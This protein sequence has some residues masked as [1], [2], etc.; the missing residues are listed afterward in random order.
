MSKNKNEESIKL[1]SLGSDMS[2]GDEDAYDPHLHREREAP[3]TNVETLIHI[4][5]GSLGTGILAMPEAFLNAGMINGTIFTIIIGAVATYGL[6][7]LVNSTYLICKRLKIPFLSYPN[8]MKEALLLGP[9]CLHKFAKCAGIVVD[10][11]LIIYQLGI[12]CVYV[13]FVASN[14]KDFCDYFGFHLQ[15]QYHMLILLVPLCLFNSVRNLKRLTP[16]STFANIITFIGFGIVVYFVV[17]DLDPIDTRKMIGTPYAFPL[18]VGTTLFALEAVGVIIAVENNMKTPKSF[19][20]W[21]G[22]LNIAM[23]VIVSLYVGMGFLGY[24]QYGEHCLGSITLNLPSDVLGMVV[25]VI[26]SIAILI[27][28]ALQCYVPIEM[29]WTTYMLPTNR[30]QNSNHQIIWEFALRFSLVFITFLLAVTIPL[31]GLFISLFGAF[32]LSALGLAFPAIIQMCARWPDNLG[33]YNWIL[34]QDILFI[35]FGILG[36]VSGTYSS[37]SEIVIKLTK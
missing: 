35:L 14:L 17:Q 34:V 1:D 13:V 16:F 12:C 6:H 31:L 25:R 23:F 24:W 30:I 26:F 4:L 37:V 18:F 2:G 22:V 10:G 33:K 15:I 5:K 3:T 28:Y 7:V 11:F 9:E 8:A 27:S 20:G 32:C 29:I 21:F 19:S 36:L